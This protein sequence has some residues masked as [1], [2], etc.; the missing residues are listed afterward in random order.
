MEI[1]AT[2]AFVQWAI[3]LSCPKSQLETETAE[4]INQVRNSG[5]KIQACNSGKRLL[6]QFIGANNRG[7]YSVAQFQIECVESITQENRSQYSKF[8]LE[9]LDRGQGTTVG[10]ALR[11]ILLSNLEGTAVTAVRIAGVSHEF[12]TIPGVREDV[13]EI[14][15]QMKEIV[16]RSHSSQAVTGR[17]LVHGATTVTA[18]HFD[19]PAEVE[20][21]DPNQ[22]VATLADGAKLEME[23]RVERGK[24][25]R[26]VERGRD[27]ATS[28]DY[29]QIDSIFMP[30]R[31]VNYSVE[32]A[33]V[34]GSLQKDRLIME[35]WTN[36]SLT[37]QEAL[38]SAANILVDL[39]TPLK[40]ISLAAMK[41]EIPADEDPTSQIPIEELQLSVRAYNCLK[42]AQVNSVADLLDYT[43]E[44]LLEIKNF[45]QKSAEEVIEALQKRLG[46]TLPHEKSS[47]PT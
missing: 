6:C 31:K 11:R 8:V 4:R 33:R 24:G 44:D 40:D 2:C 46:I 43:Q 27:E 28:I 23:F 35:I 22:Y 21:I 13:M 9:P 5:K 20:I 16:L 38:S 26:T 18:A 47:K 10:N 30:V 37:P 34:D 36:G 19:L 42:R 1:S 29:L 39:F 15:M 3:A 41:D 17:L 7:G 25:Y 14:L 45:G 32:D 12:A